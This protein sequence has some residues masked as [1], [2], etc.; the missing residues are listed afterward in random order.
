MTA[1][2]RKYYSK[3]LAEFKEKFGA[4]LTMVAAPGRVRFDIMPTP[5]RPSTTLTPEEGMWLCSQ[6]LVRPEVTR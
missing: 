6:A 5:E 4:E 1:S 2:E 3:L